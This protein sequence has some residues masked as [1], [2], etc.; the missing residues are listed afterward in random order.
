MAKKMVV[1]GVISL[2]VLLGACA[3]AVP[4]P[5]PTTPTE[6]SGGRASESKPQD[7]ESV[8]DYQVNANP[9]TNV[10]KAQA[11]IYDEGIRFYLV[12]LSKD[13]TGLEADIYQDLVERN[14]RATTGPDEGFNTDSLKCS[15]NC[16]FV[17]T[18][19]VDALSVESW[20]NVLKHEHRHMIQASHNP[21][22]ADD[23]R[24]AEGLFTT[25]AAFLE[26]CADDGIYVGE[27]IYHA[28][29]RM[30]QLKKVLGDANQSV[31]K[32]ACEG[33]KDAY[34]KVTQ[35]YEQETGQQGSFAK[36]FPQYR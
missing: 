21:T 5:P 8:A 19:V 11:L 35:L 28:S 1:A 26:V 12:V 10:A 17:P 33:D 30:P 3:T 32:S 7:T 2:C 29:V 23:F 25:F 4:N 36:L 6:S 18:E 22:M 24:D 31:L 16:V 20:A 27:E 14:I 13:S 9:Q 15:P 34:Q